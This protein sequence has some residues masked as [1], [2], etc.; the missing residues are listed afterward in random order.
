MLTIILI[1]LLIAFLFGGGYGY[2]RGN[3]YMGGGF[4]II[5]LILL[6][7]AVLHLMGKL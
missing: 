1:V 2:H 7:V 3:N 5:G 6:V 4:G